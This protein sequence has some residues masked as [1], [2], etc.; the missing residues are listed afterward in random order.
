M[1]TITY[2]KAKEALNIPKS[3]F[4]WLK[5]SH[6]LKPIERGIYSLD[7]IMTIKNCS[8]KVIMPVMRKTNDK[9]KR[10]C[11]SCLKSG[12]RL[13]SSNICIDCTHKNW[14][15]TRVINEARA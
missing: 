10:V 2:T 11:K 9:E 1:E 7:D 12:L 8:Y 4:Y 3:A 13:M 6:G 15:V 14:N 5:N